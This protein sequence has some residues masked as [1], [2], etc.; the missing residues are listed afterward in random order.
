MLSRKEVGVICCTLILILSTLLS[1]AAFF[2]E[3]EVEERIVFVEINRAGQVETLNSLDFN[4]IHRYG[5]YA[6]LEGRE[7]SVEALENTDMRVDTLPNRTEI[8]I[9]GHALD[10]KEGEPSLDPDLMINEEPEGVVGTYLIHLLGPMSP[11]WRDQLED[12]DIQIL[13]YVP[14]HAYKVRMTPETRER[15]EHFYFV[16][17][18][19]V[20][21]PQYKIYEGC[22]DE[23]DDTGRFKVKVVPDGDIDE[24]KDIQNLGPETDLTLS[25]TNSEVVVEID[26]VETLQEIA[27]LN[28]VY[29]ISPYQRSEIISQDVE[30]HAP[31]GDYY[32]T[33][34]SP[35]DDID[36]DSINQYK[37]AFHVHTE[38]SDGRSGVSERIQEHEECGFDILSIT[39]HDTRGSEEPTWRW[40]DH[41]GSLEEDWIVE[42]DG[43][44]QSA[45]YSELGDEGMLAIK[46]N[47]ISDP[48]HIGS[49]FN[50]AGWSRVSEDEALEQGKRR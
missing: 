21:H 30:K 25:K 47:E 2:G 7:D 4:I 44:E 12:M 48:H 26:D 32:Y 8:S 37:A 27:K 1:C 49:F 38:E 3:G 24:L 31:P 45:F 9:N 14:N 23:I 39:D 19:T 17:W 29:R 42:H 50:D 18:T 13:N 20:Y 33:V 16:D 22:E 40:S 11:S 6:L 34:R 41:D 46:G 10:I 36:W 15:L 35:Y 28:D 43:M 5:G